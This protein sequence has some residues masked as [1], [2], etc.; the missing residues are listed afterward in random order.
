MIDGRAPGRRAPFRR[1]PPP[2]AG[3]G[4]GRPADGVRPAEPERRTGGDR[5][6]H[7]FAELADVSVGTDHPAPARSCRRGP[8]PSTQPDPGT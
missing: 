5:Q 8:G 6:R 7:A 2:G 3:P 4:Q 1:L